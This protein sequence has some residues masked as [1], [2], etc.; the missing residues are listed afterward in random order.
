MAVL[1]SKCP[2]DPRHSACQK[3]AIEHTV[4]AVCGGPKYGAWCV[5]CTASWCRTVS[6]IHFPFFSSANMAST[7]FADP[8]Q[9]G[10]KRARDSGLCCFLLAPVVCFD[11]AGS[12]S[13]DLFFWALATAGPTLSLYVC[14]PYSYD[15]RR[16][17]RLF[18]IESFLFTILTRSTIQ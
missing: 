14:L 2:K 13:G 15:K 16:L 5:R 11:A 17:G 4:I 18:A 12:A 10:R 7:R 3:V 1:S 8:Q 9:Q 6:R